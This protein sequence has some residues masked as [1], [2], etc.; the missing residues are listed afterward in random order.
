[1]SAES[2]EY[3]ARAAY[4]AF[5]DSPPDEGGPTWEEL[6]ATNRALWHAVADAVETALTEGPP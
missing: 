2:R 5:R 3:A 6:D 4:E 1:M